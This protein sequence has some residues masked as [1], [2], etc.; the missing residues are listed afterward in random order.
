MRIS[1]RLPFNACV[2]A[3]ACETA[4][5]K[6]PHLNHTHEL[7]QGVA[8]PGLTQLTYRWRDRASGHV[9]EAQAK[10]IAM[11]LCVCLITLI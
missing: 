10:K 2:N 11:H 7:H 6:P 5:G 9:S 4:L 1:H 8:P 3:R